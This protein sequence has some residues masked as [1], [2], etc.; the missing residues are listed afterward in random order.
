MSRRIC[1]KCAVPHFEDCGTCAGF[2]VYG[3]QHGNGL[4]FVTAH[5]ARHRT[6]PAKPLPCPECKST[7]DGVP[8]PHTPTDS[9]SAESETP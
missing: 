2:G 3:S 9:Q 7:I 4:V 5:E 6:P 1:D 8:A